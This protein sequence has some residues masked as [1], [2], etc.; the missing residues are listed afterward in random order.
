MRL[1]HWKRWAKALKLEVH[2]LYLA[3]KDR[4]T[5]WYAKIIGVCVVGYA[6]SPI[7]LIPDPIPIIGYLDDLIIV[8]L[9]VLLVRRL[10]PTAVLIECRQQAESA[11]AGGKRPVNWIAGAIIIALWIATVAL[12]GWWLWR[13]LR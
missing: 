6:L 9:G 13:W 3:C 2:A 12:L 10:I 11:A 1:E 7:D 8:P 5:P 4:R